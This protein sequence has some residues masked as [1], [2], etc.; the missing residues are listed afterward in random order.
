MHCHIVV[1]R[2]HLAWVYWGDNI[3]QMGNSEKRVGKTSILT[4][5]KV[6]EKQINIYREGYVVLTKKKKE[7]SQTMDCTALL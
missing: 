4:W 7:P 2:D 5:R 1:H 3:K 6:K